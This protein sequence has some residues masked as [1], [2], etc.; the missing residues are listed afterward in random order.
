MACEPL[1]ERFADVFDG[2]IRRQNER[3]P[4]LARPNA[5]RTAAREGGVKFGLEPTLA[6]HQERQ[7]VRMVYQE[8]EG[9]R[10]PPSTIGIS[11]SNGL[12]AWASER[13]NYDILDFPLRGAQ[14]QARCHRRAQRVT[15]D[16]NGCVLV[17]VVAQ[18]N[19]AQSRSSLVTSTFSVI[20]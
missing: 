10:H 6:P 7:V 8:S 2:G 12:C 1:A 20:E 5:G 16:A 14:A 3:G 13:Q 11:S 15:N 4:D 9:P 17:R 19:L 18:K